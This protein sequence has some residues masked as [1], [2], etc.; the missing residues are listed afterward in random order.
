MRQ[1]L[2]GIMAVALIA[3][4]VVV[5]IRK[6]SLDARQQN[7]RAATDVGVSPVRRR[8]VPPLVVLHP[9]VVPALPP[10]PR[11]HL[12]ADS[13]GRMF[14]AFHHAPVESAGFNPLALPF[15]YADPDGVGDPAEANA[16]AFL[17]SDALDWGPGNYSSRHAYFVFDRARPLMAKLVHGYQSEIIASAID[18]WSATHAVGGQLTRT[19]AGCTGTLEIFDRAGGLEFQRQ[20]VEPRPYFT[21]LGDMAVAALAHFGPAP[22][23]ELAALLHEPRCRH[24]E[25]IVRLGLAAFQPSR[26]ES[27]FGLYAQILQD[28]PAFAEVRYWWAN[29]R[30]WEIDDDPDRAREV[31]RSLHDRLTPS[32]LATFDPGHCRDAALAA[33][34]PAWLDHAERLAGPDAPLVLQGR[35]NADLQAQRFDPDLC[36]RALATASRLPNGRNLTDALAHVL[37]NNPAGPN[38]ADLSASLFADGISCRFLD[39]VGDWHWQWTGIG[40]AMEQLGRPNIA[41]AA[42]EAAG[43][44]DDGSGMALRESI[45]CNAGRFAD[46]VKLFMASGVMPHDQVGV[47][48]ARWAAVAAATTRDGAALA[49]IRHEFGDLFGQ[50]GFDAVLDAYLSVTRG[51]AVNPALLLPRR[52]LQVTPPLLVLATQVDRSVEHGQF[53]GPCWS[54]VNLQPGGRL[55]WVL[56]DQYERQAPTN[57]YGPDFY[58]AL[59]WLYPDDPWVRS[60]VTDYRARAGKLKR[61]AIDLQ[62]W[63]ISSEL[64]DYA[65]DEWPIAVPTRQ[66]E[67][68][69]HVLKDAGPWVT[70]ACVH[71]LLDRGRPEDAHTMALRF[72]H[73]AVDLQNNSIGAFASRLVRLTAVPSA[74]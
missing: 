23:V 44:A 11:V 13:V 4:A 21:L 50:D 15:R 24:P 1:G 62:V 38:D 12:T 58:D 45:L 67:A 33:E 41:A 73:L 57:Q 36:R 47:E 74:K 26:A 29:Q 16:L 68:Q 22:S 63:V 3:A 66:P 18:D 35:L 37:S 14:P 70:A 59:A 25:S 64:A 7:R 51:V 71:R 43:P 10:L 5:G 6:R 28:D 65:P 34:Y 55:N 48:A 56:Y 40:F 42:F 54:L 20:Y 39:A 53:Q 46:A 72:R 27:T 69:R 17:L 9:P 60:A 19:K 52:G 8:P 32:A 31:G 2:T 30:A 61:L 49:R